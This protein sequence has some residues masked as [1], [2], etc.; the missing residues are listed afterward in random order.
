M[1]VSNEYIKYENMKAIKTTLLASIALLILGISSAYCQEIGYREKDPDG[2]KFEGEWSGVSEGTTFTISFKKDNL[3]M[4][5]NEDGS[6]IL[7]EVLMGWW[8]LKNAQ[9]E[10]SHTQRYNSMGRTIQ[11]PNVLEGT[12]TNLSYG[13]QY[14]FT[15]ELVDAGKA[16]WRITKS[17][18]LGNPEEGAVSL[19]PP[20]ECILTRV[21]QRPSLPPFN[22]GKPDDPYDLIP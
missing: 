16:Q 15:L 21:V 11:N 1:P 4:G 19:S 7:M 6:P 2:Y 8:Q 17:E 9:Q 10:V 22:P 14:Y 18:K 20:T 13:V 5:R 3:R 12:I